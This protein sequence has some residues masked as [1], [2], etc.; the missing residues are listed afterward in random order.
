MRLRHG[1]ALTNKLLI[2]KDY[3]ILNMASLAIAMV[4][5]MVLAVEGKWSRYSVRIDLKADLNF[6]GL[7]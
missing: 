2:N 4:D 3:W 6:S 1:P 5:V 7:K